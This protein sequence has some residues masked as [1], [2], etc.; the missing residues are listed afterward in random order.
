MR[1]IQFGMEQKVREM[2]IMNFSMYQ[3]KLSYVLQKAIHTFHFLQFHF[4]WVPCTENK[5]FYEK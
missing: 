1:W 3:Q 5:I 2:G 4:V